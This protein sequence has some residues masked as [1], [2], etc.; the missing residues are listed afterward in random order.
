MRY[1]DLVTDRSCLLGLRPAADADDVL[2]DCLRR[3]A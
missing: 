1:D 2:A 3:R